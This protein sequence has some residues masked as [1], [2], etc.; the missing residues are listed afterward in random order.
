MLVE[1]MPPL[2]TGGP[3]GTELISSANSKLGTSYDVGTLENAYLKNSLYD[4]GTGWWTAFSNAVDPNAID[5]VYSGG[6][7]LTDSVRW[8]NAYWGGIRG[9]RP[10]VR[11][12][13]SIRMTWDGSKWNLSI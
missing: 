8:T 12:K 13:N 5:M 3:N 11:L 1:T 6:H 7:V 9:V 10:L 4:I 2:R